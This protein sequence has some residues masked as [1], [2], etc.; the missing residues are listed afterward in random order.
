[1]KV[2]AIIPTYNEEKNIAHVVKSL[3]ES[4]IVNEII[5]IDDGSTD[6]TSERARA[7]GV[8]VICH[9][10]NKGKGIAMRTGAQATDADI[11]FFADADLIN[12]MPYHIEEL[13]GPVTSGEVGMTIGL[14]DRGA[15]LTRLLSCIAPLLGGERALTRDL[16]L[17]ISGKG[18]TDFGIE[19]LMNAY[20]KKHRILVRSIPLHGV[21]QVIK[22][23][24]YGIL[25]G[26]LARMRMI[27]QIIRAEI[28]VLLRNDL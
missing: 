21:R 17:K 15:F 22:E 5:V 23:R 19:T 24:K 4:K 27:A 6:T 2:A 16:F 10:Q 25:R 18:G 1:M 14:R 26:F 8:R 11:L 12:F 3:C 13:I 9:D 7:L 28:E 20:C